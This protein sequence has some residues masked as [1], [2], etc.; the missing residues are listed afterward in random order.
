MLELGGDQLLFVDA[1]YNIPIA[2]YQLPFIG[3]PVV[4]LRE[5][6]DGAGVG[7][8]PAIHQASGVRLAAGFLY[9]EFMVDPAR[10]QGH[11][12]AGITM[13]R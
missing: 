8:F 9:A 5:A 4:I 7:E 6:L 10:R 2:R 13:R 3:P 1:R 11:L 12:S